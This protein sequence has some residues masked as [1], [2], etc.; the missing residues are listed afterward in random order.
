MSNATVL[1]ADPGTSTIHIERVFDAPLEKVFRAFTTPEKV[2][3]WWSPFG[4][5]RIDEDNPRVGGAWR[6]AGDGSLGIVLETV[7][8]D[9]IGPAFDLGYRRVHGCPIRHQ[10]SNS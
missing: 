7:L 1:R 3:K 5:T 8:S 6:I 9:W 4:R 2:V 10:A